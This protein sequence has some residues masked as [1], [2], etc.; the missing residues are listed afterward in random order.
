MLALKEHVG[1]ASKMRSDS[2]KISCIDTTYLRYFEYISIDIPTNMISVKYDF[3]RRMKNISN[4]TKCKINDKKTRIPE[5]PLHDFSLLNFV[6]STR[7]LQIPLMTNQA[8]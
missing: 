1:H 2:H 8:F 5:L 6:C 4:N 3:T 7:I